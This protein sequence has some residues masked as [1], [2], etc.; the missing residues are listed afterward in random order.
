M[1]R[2]AREPETLRE[3]REVKGTQAE[4]ALTLGISPC[5]LSLIES[6]KRR[7]NLDLAARMS[8]V[9]G[10]DLAQVYNAYRISRVASEEAQQSAN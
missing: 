8:R 10:C 7:L 3:L 1:E 4:V 5:Y 2:E 9:F 6:G